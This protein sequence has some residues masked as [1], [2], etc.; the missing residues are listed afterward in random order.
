MTS[1]AEAA[2]AFA[3]DHAG[4][5]PRALE[6]DL[7]GVKLAVNVMSAGYERSL[8]TSLINDPRYGN[9]AQTK[10]KV[11]VADRQT[12]PDLPM[13][14]PAGEDV[15][16]AMKQAAGG[17]ANYV[18]YQ[19]DFEQWQFFDPATGF[20][21]QAMQR[22]DSYPPW[23]DSFPLVQFLHWTAMA[24][25]RRIIH[26]AALGFGGRGVVISG[27]S[28]AGKSGTTLAGLLGGLDS[29]GDD[30]VLLDIGQDRVRA[31]PMTRIMKQD[32]RGLRRNGLSP[33]DRRFV[34]PN[35]QGKYELYLAELMGHAIPE[36][37]DLAAIIL[38]RIGGEGAARL[39][40]VASRDAMMAL[41]PSNLVQLPGGRRFGVEFLADFSRRLPAYRLEL[42]ADPSSVTAVI[43][44]LIEKG[45]A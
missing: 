40:P 35:W 14:P 36:F 10:L 13:P 42:G 21:V 7:P 17:S 41:L 5:A 15:A 1:Y 11:T 23:E 18:T 9:A 44:D 34:G 8:G 37:L 3:R 32:A 4:T 31:F 16:A 20:G 26:A 39:V 6:F 25:G 29:I 38:P 22:P 12:H 2:L 19:P 45:R 24:Q 43:A 28:G 30:Y 27:N 33:D